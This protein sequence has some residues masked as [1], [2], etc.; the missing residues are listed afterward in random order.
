MTSP[1]PSAVR[2][3][4][5]LVR[6]TF[7]RH[8]RVRALAWV[9]FGL[10]ALTATA[11]GVY[12]HGP[13]GW[14]LEDRRAWI[15]DLKTDGAV[16]MTYRQ[17]ALERL[18]I[19]EFFPGPPGQLA[20]KSG[21]MGAVQWL[22]VGDHPDAQKFRNDYAFL[23]FSRWVVFGLYLG[24]A[25]PLFA[26]AY[27]SGALGGEREGRTLIWLATRPMPRGAVYLAKFVGVLPWCVL[28]SV[29]G[30]AAVCLAGGD[31]GRQAFEVYLP[32]VVAGTLG[33]SALFH[34]MGAV[35]RRPAVVGLVYVFFFETLVANLPGSLKR[36]SLNYYVRSM[37][38]NEA[39]AVAD[40]PTDQLDVYDPVTPTTAW[41]VLL[42][43]TVALTVIGMWWFARLEPKDE[44]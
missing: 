40:V 26:L 16:R 10:L 6:L 5:A 32:A 4:A 23:R 42:A 7:R 20:I 30:F 31:L 37:M 13:V 9:T 8:W 19:Y 1:A 38:Y 28:V 22:L 18:P 25:M 12:T 41:A 34:L 29:V 44:V 21:P 2:A 14:R 17:Y 35:F 3:F 43:A 27:A 39:S 33:L 24:F 15:A 11:I 36:L